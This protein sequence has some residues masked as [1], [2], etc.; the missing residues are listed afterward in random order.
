MEANLIPKLI[1]VHASE[2]AVHFLTQI[3]STTFAAMQTIG[4]RIS[5]WN[6]GDTLRIVISGR[7]EKWKEWLLAAWL[8]AWLASIVVFAAQLGGSY[9][10]GEK[11]FFG[12]LVGAM[13]YFLLRL[14]KVWMWRRYGK[15][16][17]SIS[18]EQI[19]I[20]RDHKSYGKAHSYYI[21][22]VKKFGLVIRKENSFKGELEDS[23]WVL[24]GERIGFEA[25]GQKVKFGMQLSEDDARQ[26]AGLVKN[27]IQTR[28]AAKQ[29]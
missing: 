27:E 11:L 19:T 5:F 28:K 25:L 16:L 23:F 13:L 14:G 18:N 8:V 1:K 2:H 26:L 17:I 7:T 3:C 29:N 15:E 6:D 9:S 24:G 20:K 21:E 12:V 22:N 10:Q 4:D